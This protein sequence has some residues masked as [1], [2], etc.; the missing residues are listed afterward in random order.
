MADLKQIPDARKHNPDPAYIAQLVELCKKR[1]Q[2][3]SQAAVAEC[4]GVGLTTLKDWKSGQSRP[5]YPDQFTL[6]RL[7]GI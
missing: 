4:I 7:A 3:G 1:N 5:S 6:E 2:L